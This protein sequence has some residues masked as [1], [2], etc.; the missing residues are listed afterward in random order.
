M[1][2]GEGAAATQF[3]EGSWGH[4]W[5]AQFVHSGHYHL[6]SRNLSVPSA[7]SPEFPPPLCL[8]SVVLKSTCTLDDQ[9]SSSVMQ[10]PKLKILFHQEGLGPGHG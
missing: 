9:G 8:K 4:T 10:I 7:P 2:L 5:R 1:N 3:L 6:S